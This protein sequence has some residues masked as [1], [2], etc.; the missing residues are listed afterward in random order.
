MRHGL[1]AQWGRG[2]ADDVDEAVR[3]LDNESD[4]DFPWLNGSEHAADFSRYDEFSEQ[5][6]HDASGWLF[7]FGLYDRLSLSGTAIT[8]P[9]SACTPTL[10]VLLFAGQGRRP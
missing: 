8:E 1:G 5:A 9:G 6:A 7:D 4:A 3:E 10:S 2:L